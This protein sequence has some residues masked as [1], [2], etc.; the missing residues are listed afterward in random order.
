M[1]APF[2][3]VILVVGLCITLFMFDYGSAYYSS[4]NPHTCILLSKVSHNTSLIQLFIVI[5]SFT[6]IVS[7]YNGVVVFVS[8][9]SFQLET[10]FPVLCFI[11]GTFITLSF[12]LHLTVFTAGI[13]EV[14][15]VLPRIWVETV[16]F[17]CPIHARTHRWFNRLLLKN[18]L[19]CPASLYPICVWSEALLLTHYWQVVPSL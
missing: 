13:V 6:C 16:K 12:G 17:H 5:K 14:D 7:F 2:L 4:R 1:F 9:W 11:Y 18:D 8:L 19:A 15:R 3:C 10:Q